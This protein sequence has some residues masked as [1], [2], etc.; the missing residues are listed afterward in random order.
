MKLILAALVMATVTACSS[1]KNDESLP[2]V[3]HSSMPVGYKAACFMPSDFNG[4][5]LKDFVVIATSTKENGDQSSLRDDS[6][7][8]WVLVYFGRQDIN[9][10]KYDLAGQNDT[11][12]LPADGGGFA[13]PC[14]PAF[15]QGD[16]LAAKGA[17][18]TVENQVACGAHC[19][20]YITFKYSHIAKAMVFDNAIF[21]SSGF[22][23]K[24]GE[25]G[26]TNRWVKKAGSKVVLFKDYKSF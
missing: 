4:D 13:A 10:L 3:I 17:Y 19:T 24:T 25:F 1:A 21:E 23:V 8:R 22:N 20:D 9:G 14:D 5:G 12:A 11:L 16:G 7:K 2:R 18:F 6:P 26:V 15:D